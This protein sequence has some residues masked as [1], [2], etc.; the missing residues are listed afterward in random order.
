MES[1][2]C[3]V[4]TSTELGAASCC[5]G[6][7]SPGLS[8]LVLTGEELCQQGK[9]LIYECS[10]VTIFSLLSSPSMSSFFPPSLPHRCCITCFMKLTLVAYRK[11]TI[12]S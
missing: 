9:L 1:L 11:G 3:P 6:A 8:Q 7:V 5:K 10:F 12:D 4:S 2:E